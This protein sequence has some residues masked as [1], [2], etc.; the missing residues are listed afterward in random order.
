MATIL[1][2]GVDLYLRGKLEASLPGH[3]LVTTDSADPPDCVVADVSRVDPDDVA[4]AYPD[5]PILGFTNHTDTAGLR[6]AHEAGFDQVVAKS[7]LVERSPEL[8][9]GLIASVD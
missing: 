9:D 3:H 5:S 7:A 2:V 8:I 1:L 4:D 6:R